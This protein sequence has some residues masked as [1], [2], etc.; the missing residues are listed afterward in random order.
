MLRVTVVDCDVRAAVENPRHS[1]ILIVQ[2]AGVN[3]V[4]EAASQVI[5]V[6]ERLETVIVLAL[7][8]TNAMNSSLAVVV[9]SA[10]ML[11]VVPVVQ[12]PVAAGVVPASFAGAEP[13]TTLV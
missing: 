2:E 3:V 9:V 5:P 8:T 12:V 1:V 10:P 7:V 6:V 4:R 13:S 11:K